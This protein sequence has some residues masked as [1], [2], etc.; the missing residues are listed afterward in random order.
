MPPAA[1]GALVSHGDRSSQHTRSGQTTHIY[2]KYMNGMGLAKRAFS[3]A[4]ATMTGTRVMEQG[5][6]YTYGHSE[7][8]PFPKAAPNCGHL[9]L[10]TPTNHHTAP[11]CS[12]GKAQW[13]TAT[14]I[15]EPLCAASDSR[16]QPENPHL[17][18]PPHPHGG[19]I[20]SEFSTTPPPHY[21]P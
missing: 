15:Q 11:S 18:L 9:F 3:A 12:Q 5:L 16:E 14:D 21:C 19:D 7:V 17:A 4:T 8:S 2:T 20:A 1:E 10:H 6:S 13:C